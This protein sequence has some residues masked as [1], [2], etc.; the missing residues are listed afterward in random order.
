MFI[1]KAMMIAAAA[2]TAAIPSSWQPFAL[3]DWWVEEV[4]DSCSMFIPLGGNDSDELLGALAL[5]PRRDGQITL[6]LTRKDWPLP[7]ERGTIKIW[8]DKGYGMLRP[9]Y[10]QPADFEPDDGNGM[11]VTVVDGSFITIASIK[12]SIDVVIEGSALGEPQRMT[13]PL[14]GL[15]TAATELDECLAGG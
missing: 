10:D 6:T 8:F 2:S 7:K 12:S 9:I 15:E 4:G 14:D 1:G 3:G 13:I 11:V 5:I